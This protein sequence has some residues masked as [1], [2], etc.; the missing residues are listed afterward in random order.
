MLFSINLMNCFFVSPSRCVESLGPGAVSGGGRSWWDWPDDAPL[1][2]VVK[3]STHTHTDAPSPAELSVRPRCAPRL[4]SPVRQSCARVSAGSE[5]SKTREQT[6]ERE[7]A[8]TMSASKAMEFM[9]LSDYQVKVLENCFNK[10]TKHPDGATLTLIAAECGLTEEQ[11]LVSQSKCLE[12]RRGTAVCYSA[13]PTGHFWE[14]DPISGS[15]LMRKNT[16]LTHV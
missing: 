7:A 14:Y 10:D 6:G 9:K 13:L 1:L 12:V 2:T 5:R 11:T 3:G 15:G 16:F 8:A 4:P